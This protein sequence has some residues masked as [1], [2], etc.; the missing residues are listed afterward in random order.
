[1]ESISFSLAENFEKKVKDIRTK[2]DYA[3][4]YE[5]GKNNHGKLF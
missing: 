3:L 4:A 5:E 2:L 1:M